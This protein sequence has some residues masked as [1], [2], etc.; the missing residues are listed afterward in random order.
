MN[1]LVDTNILIPLE[2][3]NQ[4]LNNDLAEMKRLCSEINWK[5]LLHPKQFED[6]ARDSDTTRRKIMESR[7]A[8]YSQLSSPPNVETEWLEKNNIKQDSD[9]DKVDNALLFAMCRSA[10]KYLVTEDKA[11][12]KK[13]SILGRSEYVLRLSQFLSI[14]RKNSNKNNSVPP[15]GLTEKFLYQIEVEQPF[16]DSLRDSYENFNEWYERSSATHRKAW[17][18]IQKSVLLAICI[19]KEETDSVINDNGDR[20]S[21]ALKL[22]TFKVAP[23]ARGQKYGERLLYS[24]FKFAHENNLSYVYLH[25]RGKEH[26][27]LVSLCEEY[28]FIRDGRYQGDDVLIKDMNKPNESTLSAL[29]Y[30]IKHYPYFKVDQD[31]SC[32]VIPIIPRYHETLFPDISDTSREL[33]RDHSEMYSTPSHTIKKAYVC[34]ANIRKIKAGDIVLFYRSH[35]RRNIQVIGIVEQSVVSKDKEKI[36][37]LTSKRTVFTEDELSSFSQKNCLIILFRLQQIL[38]KE[39]L[40]NNSIIRGSIQSIREISWEKFFDENKEVINW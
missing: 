35:D 5:L 10:V 16:F 23:D 26:E 34:H 22:C 31:T 6:I 19:H 4:P 27:L 11:M 12:H 18:I 37:A 2:N 25:A 13:A 39:A 24:A 8:Q 28:G 29:Q 30:S 9:N 1:I 14:L 17:C 3:T 36:I 38:K 20:L 7:L 40:L 32:Y 33:F 15:A 21:S